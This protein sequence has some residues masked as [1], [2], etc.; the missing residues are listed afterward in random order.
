MTLPDQNILT[1]MLGDFKV[2][3]APASGIIMPYAK[4][5]LNI[6]FTIE[7]TMAYIMS[8]LKEEDAGLKVLYITLFKY[9]TFVFLLLNYQTIVNQIILSFQLIGLKAAGGNISSSDF[10]NPSLICEKGL[11]LT[12]NLFTNV[13]AGESVLNVFTALMVLLAAIA[14]I[15]AFF[16]IGVEI[17]I[18]N[19]EFS[20]VAALGLILV[21]FGMLTHT[22]FM[23]DKIKEGIINFGIKY[24]VLAFVA[25]ISMS[26]VTQWTQLSAGATFQQALYMAFGSCTLAYLCHHAP[27]VAS[28]MAS[29]SGGGGMGSGIGMLSMMSG[30]VAGGGA[31]VVGAQSKAKKATASIVNS[32]R[33][34]LNP[35]TGLR[36]GGLIGRGGSLDKM[37]GMDIKDKQMKTDL[38]QEAV[39]SIQNPDYTSSYMDTH[40]DKVQLAKADVLGINDS[41]VSSSFF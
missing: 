8:L 2:K 27:S 15:F 14:I 3:I 32:I 39:R 11:T 30:A 16:I 7:L 28:S 19:V 4:N 13:G 35:D 36:M 10:T 34:T 37:S 31:A 29:G 22:S 20:I 26:I 38:R 9:G 18:V 40:M 33:G 25:S 24:M 17:F 12:A 23:F 21:P 1:S 6:L 41:P 5:T